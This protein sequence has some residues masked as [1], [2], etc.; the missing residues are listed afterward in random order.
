MYNT[1]LPTRAELPSTKQL[2]R[3]TALAI[4]TAGTL[5]ITT[6][7]P[8]EYGIDPTG[9]GRVLGLTA[10]GEVKVLLAQEAQQ[11]ETAAVTKQAVVSTP[12]LTTVNNNGL[13]AAKAAT[14]LQTH[15]MTIKLEPDQA[16]EV[17][18][19]MS[20]G[21]KVTY[22]WT[23][24]GPLNVDAHG[25]PVNPPA[26]FYHGYGKGRQITSRDGEIQAAFDGKHGWFWRNR[27]DRVVILK[28]RTS[29]EYQSIRQVL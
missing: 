23:A 8:S 15:Q 29:G 28:L 26:G 6:V 1:D 7:L 20:K 27:T 12:N 16:A 21:A 22:Q 17:K 11:E 9:I 24:D 2:L 5:L 4:L 14:A 18:L 3:S 10:M 25:D 19:A 13:P